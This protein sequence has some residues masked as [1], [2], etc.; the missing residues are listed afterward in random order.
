MISVGQDIAAELRHPFYLDADGVNRPTG[1]DK[2][3]Y[4]ARFAASGSGVVRVLRQ[5]G[6][7]TVPAFLVCR[8]ADV[9]EV[10]RRQEVF[11]RA[12]AA[13]ADQTDVS[14]TMLG[15]DGAE[16]ARVRG[17]VKDA[18]TKPAVADLSDVVRAAADAHVSALLARGRPADLV[19]DFAIPFS[20]DVICDILGLPRD[21]RMQFRR[22]GDMFLGAGDLSRD[23]AARS[24]MEMGGYLWGQLEARRGCPA[25][26]LLTRIANG[27]ADQPMD[28]QIKLPIALVVGGWETV[29]SGITTFVH[30]LCSRGYEPG[31]TGW[32][33]LLD[34][35]DKVD[36]AVTE[37]ERLFSPTNGDDMP[38]RVMADVRL[39]SGHQLSEGDI[40]IPSHDA[41]N[42]DPEVFRDPERMDFDRDPNPHLSFGFGAHYCIG[43]HLGAFE[44]RT[45]IRTLLREL[46]GLRLAVPADEVSWKPGHTI[47]GP[48]AL[49]VDW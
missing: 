38:R 4:Y 28:I 11:S 30:V 36:S 31:R 27:A 6:G 14:G 13:P 12:A 26:D 8:Y 18:F 15:M 3:P 7:E 21:D 19:R 43:A 42:R 40:V 49:P 24:A 5:V 47:L 46:P 32:E 20:L 35:P 22:W 44:V 16:H 9:R 39:P 45:A 41:A 10:L 17:A 25:G 37:L 1:P 2:H 29:A 48:V 34:H 23:D 33:Y